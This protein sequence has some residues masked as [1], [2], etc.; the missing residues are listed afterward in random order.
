MRGAAVTGM[1]DRGMHRAPGRAILGRLR[2]GGAAPV[3]A[4]FPGRAYLLETHV[5]AV[6]KKQ[7]ESLIRH[8]NLTGSVAACLRS[9]SHVRG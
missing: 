6:P 8:L 2:E 9:F 3:G 1:P 5:S 4:N 7:L